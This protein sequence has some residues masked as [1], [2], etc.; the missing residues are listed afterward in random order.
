LIH[1]HA[2]GNLWAEALAHF[3]YI[4]NRAFLIEEKVKGKYR[5]TSRYNKVRGKH[6]P[7]NLEIFHAFGILVYA[8]LA[9]PNR[10]G[11]PFEGALKKKCV[12]CCLL[13][14]VWEEP[15][16]RLLDLKTKNILE[17]PYSWA[18]THEGSFPHKMSP[19]AN[20][21]AHVP[22]PSFDAD[23]DEEISRLA[24]LMDPDVD[25]DFRYYNPDVVVEES[26][27]RGVLDKPLLLEGPPE[28]DADSS[29]SRRSGRQPMPSA[30][31]LRNVAAAADGAGGAGDADNDHASV[32]TA[33][34][35]SGAGEHVLEPTRKSQPRFRKG[36]R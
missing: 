29:G 31:Q 36:S 11:K 15:M 25:V 27:S 19:W 5:N 9:P 20:L 24:H 34:F 35:D 8:F 2:P 6:L 26:T 1:A 3:C 10:V 30:Q 16:Y 33:L 12:V 7:Q 22:L 13:G 14:Y 23:E 17:C 4:Y 32:R 18:I 21:E 28:T